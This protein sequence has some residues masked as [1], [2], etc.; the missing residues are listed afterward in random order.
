GPVAIVSGSRS[1]GG[2]V[3]TRRPPRL[4]PTAR[5]LAHGT[6]RAASADVARIAQALLAAPSPVIIAG[7]GV[8][9]SRA[10]T[11]LAELAE[12]LAIPVDTKENG[13][14]A[15]ADVHRLVMGVFGFLGHTVANAEV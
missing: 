3:K 14:S 1:F 15:I 10:W 6:V 5:H 13:K 11:E 4:H 2:T 8:H 7:N 9:A 12:L